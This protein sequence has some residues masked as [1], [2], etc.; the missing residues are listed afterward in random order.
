MSEYVFVDEKER[1][2][3]PNYITKAFKK[4]LRDGEFDERLKFHSLR[5]TNLSM[6]SKNG[7][8]RIVI[9]DLAGHSRTNVTEKYITTPPKEMFEAVRKI[10]LPA[11][12]NGVGKEG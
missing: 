5:A 10:Q 2:Y 1:P 4:C 8:S 9:R 7:A 6:L 11:S 3:K 12:G